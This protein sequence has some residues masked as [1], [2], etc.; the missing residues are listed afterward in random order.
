MAHQKFTRKQIAKMSFREFLRASREPYQRLFSYLRPYRRRFALGI[1]FG[2]LYGAVQGLL[3][4]D[5]QFIAGAVFPE[6]R[7]RTPGAL[8]RDFALTL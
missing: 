7:S 4:F 3:I 8:V 6:G 1:L 5:I 2:A